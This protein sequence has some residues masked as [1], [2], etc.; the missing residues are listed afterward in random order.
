[1]QYTTYEFFVISMSCRRAEHEVPQRWLRC[2]K[3]E[4]VTLLPFVLLLKL[5]HMTLCSYRSSNLSKWKRLSKVA[6][7]LNMDR[8]FNWCLQTSTRQNFEPNR[9]ISCFTSLS[10]DL[11][12]GMLDKSGKG[13]LDCLS[14]AVHKTVE[15]YLSQWTNTINCSVMIINFYVV[16]YSRLESLQ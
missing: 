3:F 10:S 9:T 16:W 8:H 2:W 13:Q 14:H 1:M 11:G 15:P 7:S 5:Y 4:M 12:E 6:C